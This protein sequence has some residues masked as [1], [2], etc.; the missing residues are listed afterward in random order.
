MTVSANEEKSIK[1][2]NNNIYVVY[3]FNNIVYYKLIIT[4]FYQIVQKLK[5]KF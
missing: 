3:S 4:R 5:S 2:W 1:K